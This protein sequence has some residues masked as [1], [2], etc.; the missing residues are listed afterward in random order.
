MAINT[1][2]KYKGHSIEAV[3]SRFYDDPKISIENKEA[4]RKFV[5]LCA[6]ENLSVLR[7]R[8]Y[9]SLYKKLFKLSD[10]KFNLATATEQ[11]IRD[12]VVRIHETDIAEESK[13]DLKVAIK[14][15]YK[16]TNHGKVP[17]K[18]DWI[19]C[20][21]KRSERKLPENLLSVAEAEKLI[22][23]CNHDRDRALI[24]MLYYGGLRI[25]E[26]GSLR[27][28][29]IVFEEYGVRLHVP[30]G[31]TGARQIL[32][33]EAEPYLQSWLRVHPYQENLNNPLWIDIEK[34]YMTVMSYDAIRMM[35]RRR[36]K[37]AGVRK[38]KV[39]PHNFRHSR[40]TYLAN[41]LTESQ[42]CVFFGW[43]QGSNMPS[44]YVHLSGR[45]LDNT[46][47]EMH[48]FQPIKK[49]EEREAR[50]CSRCSKLNPPDALFCMR[51]RVA[52]TPEAM[53]MIEKEE[54][55][56][57]EFM[58]SLFQN[59]KF[60]KWFKMEFGEPEVKLVR[61]TENIT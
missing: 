36:A 25:G 2:Y 50:R 30:N 8:K 18:V 31:K 51:C 12:L 16:I 17:E 3:K 56:T 46:L 54:H 19:K 48:N 22:R 40:A 26:L 10:Y 55:K 24:A 9:Y 14:K 13:K 34:R 45:D 53:G 4:V 60:Q 32:L 49:Q 15:F 58:K 42:L 47:M 41:Y 23:Q 61:V 27:I 1:I 57:Q 28:K 39:N 20:T 43:V 6:S 21:V 52:L 35:L 37:E 38:D 44:T 33:I 59:N 11:D 7:I 29:D 5:Q